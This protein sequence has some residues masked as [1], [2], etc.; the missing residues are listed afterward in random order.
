MSTK[1]KVK[2]YRDVFLNESGKKVL[3][4]IEKFTGA[5][6]PSHTPG[7]PYTTAFKEGMRRVFLRL[8]SLINMDDTTLKKL[9]KETTNEMYE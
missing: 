4:D 9:S 1:D 3:E 7:D 6:A 5:R 8:D 2:L